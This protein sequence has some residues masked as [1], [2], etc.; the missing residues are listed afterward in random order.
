MRYEACEWW[1]E[2][3]DECW[4]AW[5]HRPGWTPD[6]SKLGDYARR[7]GLLDSLI[8]AVNP[9]L[10]QFKSHGGKLLSYYGWN[11]A[12]GGLTS[13]RRGLPLAGE[14]RLADTVGKIDRQPER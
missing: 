11:D 12:M 3:N 1:T 10:R 8:S 4:D 13:T 2:T 5:N 14:H 7:T 6:P 9:D